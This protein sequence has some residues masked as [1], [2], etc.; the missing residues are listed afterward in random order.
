M[1]SSTETAAKMRS[2]FGKLGGAIAPL[3]DKIAEKLP[4]ILNKLFDLID[5]LADHIELLLPILAGAL[6]LFGGLASN[7]PVLGPAIEKIT[8]PI[9]ILKDKFLEL[10][11]ALKILFAILG[12]GVFKAIK[13]GKLNGPLKSIFDIVLM[14]F[15]LFNLLIRYIKSELLF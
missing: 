13:D 12:A 9:G 6:T 8:G 3:I 15:Q 10:N 1:S 2:A 7:V 11:P 14:C 5:K 4:A